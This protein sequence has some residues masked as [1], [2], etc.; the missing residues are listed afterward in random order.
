MD[1]KERIAQIQGTRDFENLSDRLGSTLGGRMKKLIREAEIADKE[2]D[3][4]HEVL[5]E[6]YNYD[7]VRHIV[8]SALDK[9]KNI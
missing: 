6:L 1:L 2:L 8:T 9:I 7:N 3:I 5:T 4:V